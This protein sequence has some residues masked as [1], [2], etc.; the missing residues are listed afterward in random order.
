MPI[1][2]ICKLIGMTKRA[3]RQRSAFGRR[4][5]QAREQAKLTQM[6]VQKA[7]RCLG[8]ARPRATLRG[9]SHEAPTLLQNKS[10]T[11]R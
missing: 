9:V 3:E 7:L 2:Y 8:L 11:N 6:D 1:V 10:S 4:M 5:L